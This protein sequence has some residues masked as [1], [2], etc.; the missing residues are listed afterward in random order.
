MFPSS[1]KHVTTLTYELE[2]NQREL[3]CI[4]FFLFLR[5]LAQPTL[6]HQQN[7][8]HDSSSKSIIALVMF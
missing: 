8:K 7:S 2:Q 6:H 5:I 3:N 1:F 4:V